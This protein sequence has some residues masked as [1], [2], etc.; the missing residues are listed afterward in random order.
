MRKALPT[1]TACELAPVNEAVDGLALHA[2]A[3][4]T[5]SPAHPPI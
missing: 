3:L 5:K 2:H 4:A 1:R